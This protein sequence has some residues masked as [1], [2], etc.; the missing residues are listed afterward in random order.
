MKKHIIAFISTIEIIQPN[1]ENNKQRRGWDCMA[2]DGLNRHEKIHLC[3]NDISS[4]P[5]SVVKNIL[6]LPN[7]YFVY[8]IH[9]R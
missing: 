9:N 6:Q 7:F 3:L 5:S 8:I 1:Y 4:D 2:N